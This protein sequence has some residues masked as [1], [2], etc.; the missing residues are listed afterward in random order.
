MMMKPWNCYCCCHSQFTIN[1]DML[2]FSIV[3]ERRGLGR[4]KKYN[5]WLYH[6]FLVQKWGEVNKRNSFGVCQV[7]VQRE[8]FFPF[9]SPQL[10]LHSVCILF[11]HSFPI[12]SLFMCT[13]KESFLHSLPSVQQK[14][15]RG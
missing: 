7:C 1:M 6:N 3:I 13:R 2:S 9:T 5:K 15:Q 8:F 11:S 12:L 10:T 4:R 14:Q